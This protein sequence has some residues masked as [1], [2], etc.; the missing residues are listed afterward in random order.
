MFLVSKNY[1]D[2]WCTKYWHKTHKHWSILPSTLL[3]SKCSLT[4]IDPTSF[5]MWLNISKSTYQSKDWLWGKGMQNQNISKYSPK[6]NLRFHTFWN[7]QYLI[8][9]SLSYLNHLVQ[10]H[11]FHVKL[12]LW[13]AK[14]PI[15][16]TDSQ[17]SPFNQSV[18]TSS[19]I[20]PYFKDTMSD[21]KNFA[22]KLSW[23]K[24]TSNLRIA[25]VNFDL[26]TQQVPFDVLSHIFTSKNK[27]F[28]S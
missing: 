12:D 18:M 26:L 19:M 21:F 27:Q 28:C 8:N 5:N 20:L 7:L 3:Q 17:I 4:T 15:L 2:L 24:Q 16:C 13:I 11:C 1:G 10:K 14:I 9:L 6:V 25:K 23:K 22:P